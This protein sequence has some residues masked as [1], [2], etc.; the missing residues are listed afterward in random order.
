[1]PSFKDTE[2]RTWTLRI[3]VSTIRRIKDL[4]GVDFADLDMFNQGGGLFEVTSDYLKFG[5]I[6]YAICK[7]EADARSV[8]E[9]AFLDAISGEVLETA[10]RAFVEAVADFFP[11]SRGNLIRQTLQAAEKVREQALKQAGE[12]LTEVME[13]SSDLLKNLPEFAE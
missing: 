10:T 6:L 9:E 12:K 8:Q 3:T 11:P 1:M 13:T 7:P 2:G 4:A 5:A